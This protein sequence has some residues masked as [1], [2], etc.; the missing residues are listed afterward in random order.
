M[1]G[2]G[3]KEKRSSRGRDESEERDESGE[4]DESDERDESEERGESEERNESEEG[5][6]FGERRGAGVELA[7]YYISLLTGMGR[8][9]VC[10][11]GTGICL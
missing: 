10:V 5:E 4:R 7:L 3:G 8:V 2:G 1:E 6:R 9:F 11:N